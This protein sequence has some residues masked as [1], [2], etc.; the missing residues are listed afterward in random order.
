M[1]DIRH[2]KEVFGHIIFVGRVFVAGTKR[3]GNCFTQ[4]MKKITKL[5]TVPLYVRLC[6]ASCEIDSGVH[7]KI[8]SEQRLVFEALHWKNVV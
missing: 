7:L 6:L 3:T 2:E 5:L 4:W 1:R 8:P